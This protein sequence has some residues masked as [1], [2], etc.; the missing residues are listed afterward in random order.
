MLYRFIYLGY[1]SVKVFGGEL[2]VSSK[3]SFKCLELSFKVCYVNALSF[4]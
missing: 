1:C 2:I 3:S 4:N